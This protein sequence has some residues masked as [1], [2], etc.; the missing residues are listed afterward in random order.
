MDAGAVELELVLTGLK[1]AEQ[2]L[3]SFQKQVAAK[4]VKPAD[5]FA[6]YNK[7]AAK[8]KQQRIDQQVVFSVKGFKVTQGQIRRFKTGVNGAAAAA[9]KAGNQIK[10]AGQNMRDGLNSGLGQAIGFGTAVAGFVRVTRAAL[11]FEKAQRKLNMTLGAE[12]A[13]A[14]KFTTQLAEQYGLGINSTASAFGSFTA[15]ASRANVALET[16]KGLFSA[17]AKSSV[18]FGLSQQQSNLAFY[19]VQQM[20]SKGVISMEELRRQL[21]E[22]IPVASAAMARGL[23]IPIRELYNLIESG[24]L[25]ATDALPALAKGLEELTGDVPDIAAT[26]L[27]RL[28]TAIEGLEIA[29]GQKA[30]PMLTPFIEKLTQGIGLLPELSTAFQLDPGGMLGRLTTVGNAMGAGDAGIAAARDLQSTIELFDEYGVTQ[31]RAI[32][33]YKQAQKE[34]GGA[35]GSAE[36]SKR[37][38]EILVK[39]T[40]AQYDS[41]EAARK[42]REAAEAAAKAEED[43]AK[44]ISKETKALADQLALEN[45]LQQLR[46][47]I[48]TKEV[49]QRIGADAGQAF[50][51]VT[52]L[53]ASIAA[54]KQA[55]AA[56]RAALSAYDT[57]NK[58]SKTAKARQNQEL[59]AEKVRLAFK[60]AGLS[61][62]EAFENA[63]RSAEDAARSVRDAA[64]SYA[65][66]LASGDKGISSL[67]RGRFKEGREDAGRN[68]QVAQALK[69][70]NLAIK[71]IQ[72]SQ[73]NLARVDFERQYSTSSIRGMSS[74]QLTRFTQA[75]NTEIDAQGALKKSNEDLAKANN[76]LAAV[77]KIAAD[78]GIKV[79]E[80][81]AALVTSLSDLV[82]KDWSVVVNVP[83][84]T[85]SGDAIQVQN[86]LS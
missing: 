81:S 33:A 62:E 67:Q 4:N 15:A 77:M 74:E 44:A 26:K 29:I 18:A 50:D 48:A 46:D 17:L 55:Q 11:N 7:A 21:G 24:N 38:I 6:A 39:E 63:K 40:Q 22:Q 30:I 86:A 13:G 84:A 64:S 85:T 31:Q 34:T 60:E 27:G 71:E 56:L 36:V 52:G 75:I 78:N 37:T 73:G 80:N 43:R 54:E 69:A 79:N 32:E 65:D 53:K 23:G 59:A 45:K 72:K 5:P 68:L 51:A 1:K 70:R 42:K 57:T 19:A 14:L 28:Q 61:I 41:I 47:R 58:D 3:Q 9:K 16:Q 12:A 8:L 82:N 20:A 49:S 76:N 10:K 66:I 83:G 25:A 35:L 2:Q